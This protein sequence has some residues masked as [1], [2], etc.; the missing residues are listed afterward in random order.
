MAIPQLTHEHS[1]AGFVEL[2][3]VFH[4]NICN[5]VVPVEIKFLQF[6]QYLIGLG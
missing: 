5:V 6:I 1:K 4:N 2:D 3:I